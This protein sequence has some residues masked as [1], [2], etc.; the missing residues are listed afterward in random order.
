MIYFVW[1]RVFDLY[2]V[3]TYDKFKQV[4]K[5]QNFNGTKKADSKF[6]KENIYSIMQNFQPKKKTESMES[7]S[8]LNNFNLFHILPWPPL[9]C[10][11][12]LVLRS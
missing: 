4:E 3:I 1:I 8:V 5:I 12:S 6:D 7:Q 11:K 2:C 9:F 10:R